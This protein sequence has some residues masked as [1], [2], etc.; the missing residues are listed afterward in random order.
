M[1]AETLSIAALALSTA[2]VASAEQRVGSAPAAGTRPR[3]VDRLG[4]L[5]PDFAKLQSGG[6]SGVVG[7]GLGYA[8][9][10]DVLNL[11]VLYGYVPR[12]VAGKHV[13]A[14]SAAFSVRPFEIDLDP[15]RVLPLYAG[16]GVLH[17]WGSG[18]F[19][20][21]PERYSSGYYR[22]TGVHASF[23]LGVEL[24]W[25]PSSASWLERHGTFAELT[26]LEIFAGRY[27]RNPD[28]LGIHEVASLALGYRAAF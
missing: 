15:L 18:Y 17:T 4:F 27:L 7:L 19:L 16:A 21:L 25:L 10:D 8:A 2:D 5:A 26:V 11:T 14:L 9:F 3:D 24:D 20:T 12:A 1:I 13:H 28:S 22:P 6:Y 23:H